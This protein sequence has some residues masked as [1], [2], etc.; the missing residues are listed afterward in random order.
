[1]NKVID[2][3]E[4][5]TMFAFEKPEF[6]ALGVQT[7]MAIPSV[8]F[9]VNKHTFVTTGTGL[10][11]ANGDMQANQVA[12]AM[13]V[14]CSLP[15]D[16]AEAEKWK[17]HFTPQYAGKAISHLVN[18]GLLNFARMELFKE[19]EG[20]QLEI[21]VDQASHHVNNNVHM[22]FA[23]AVFPSTTEEAMSIAKN[24][25]EMANQQFSALQRALTPPPSATTH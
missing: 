6:L 2:F 25:M 15:V 21:Q 10:I 16:E 20:F 7:A 24:N 14:S 12:L 5:P 18:S 22:Y 4:Q 13:T 9:A 8:A 19:G 17:A 11:V 1:M 23:L 3:P